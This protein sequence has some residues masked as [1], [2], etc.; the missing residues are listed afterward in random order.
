MVAVDVLLDGQLLFL[1]LE[2]AWRQKT[3]RDFIRDIGWTEPV[4]AVVVPNFHIH[5]SGL[6]IPGYH[7]RRPATRWRVSPIDKR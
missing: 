7:P 6:W 2:G 1:L 3:V 5:G 4:R